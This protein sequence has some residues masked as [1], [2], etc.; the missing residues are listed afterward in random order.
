MP[1]KFHET[2]VAADDAAGSPTARIV[3]Q[4][5]PSLEP[6]KKDVKE[7]NLEPYWADSIPYVKTMREL[8][9]VFGGHFLLMISVAMHLNKGFCNTQAFYAAGFLVQNRA[10]V[11]PRGDV[12]ISASRMPWAMKP[13]IAL[14]SDTRPIRGYKKLPYMLIL[15]CVGV[16]GV[17]ITSF[18]PAS[19]MP[20]EAQMIGIFCGNAAWSC[21]DILMEG[22]YSRR[23]AD[24]AAYG[25]QLVTFV[26]AGMQLFG[27]LPYWITTQLNKWAGSEGVGG[28]LG[29]QWALMPCVI[30]LLLAVYPLAANWMGEVPVTDEEAREHN[31][32]LL[33]QKELIFLSV[34]IGVLALAMVAVNLLAKATWVSFMFAATFMAFN[35]FYAVFML[36]PVIG[37]LVAF[38]AIATLSNMTIGGTVLLYFFTSDATIYPDGPHF[39]M[40]FYK[41][42]MPT[43][44]SVVSIIAIM[45]YG[46][47]CKAWRYRSLYFAGSILMCVLTLPNSILY[48]RLNVDWGIS[49]YVFIIADECLSQVAFF[50]LWMPAFLILS[51]VC[52]KNVESTVFA[53]LAAGS[54]FGQ[55]VATSMSSMLASALGVTPARKPNE[56]SKYDNLWIMNLI[57]GGV[58][59]LPILFLWL[60]PPHRQNESILAEDDQISATIGSPYQRIFNRPDRVTEDFKREQEMKEKADH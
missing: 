44:A 41:S 40:T 56:G 3:E 50:M 23:L 13:L 14:L 26:W 30:P 45:L 49:D 9:A 22:L 19:A 37:N 2:H 29:G 27:I 21:L 1:G 35:T 12:L 48:K 16:V 24:N 32:K 5:G 47:F 36:R 8:T 6:P 7:L 55:E 33:K 34:T 31:R 42:V 58:K 59:L 51:R 38:K 17:S 10:I 60:L 4:D 43:V 46:K 15:T 54:N 57:A 11:G 53:M 25:P 52:P 18:V 20:I 39:S 28:L